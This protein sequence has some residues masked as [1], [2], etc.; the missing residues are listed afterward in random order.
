M[1]FLARTEHDTVL[2]RMQR[3]TERYVVQRMRRMVASQQSNHTAMTVDLS[4]DMN[5]VRR[6]QI[7]HLPNMRNFL[8]ETESRYALS[9]P[10]ASTGLIKWRTY[11]AHVARG[12][13]IQLTMQ[14]NSQR[15]ATR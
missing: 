2:V 13:A 11:E 4:S 14:V 6:A 3:Q 1:A 8:I 15:I 7:A 9:L 10:I 5:F 12:F